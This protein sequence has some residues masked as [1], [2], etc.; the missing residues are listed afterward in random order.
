MFGTYTTKYEC[1][2][3][4]VDAIARQDRV[5]PLAAQGERV[6]ACLLEIAGGGLGDGQRLHQP[7][8]EGDIEVAYRVAHR[9]VV[10]LLG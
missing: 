3:V 7:I 6:G 5:R 8:E 10:Q 1:V 2:Q 4:Q 9:E